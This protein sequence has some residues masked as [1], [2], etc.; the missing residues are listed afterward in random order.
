MRKFSDLVSLKT[1]VSYLVRLPDGALEQ[2]AMGK[3]GPQF[4]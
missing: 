1:H 4:V 3:T 2:M